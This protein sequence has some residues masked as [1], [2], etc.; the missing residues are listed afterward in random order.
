MIHRVETHMYTT[1]PEQIIYVFSTLVSCILILFQGTLNC[2]A[3]QT[4]LNPN[5]LDES[6]QEIAIRTHPKGVTTGIT[7]TATNSTL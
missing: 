3:D 7:I 1:Q 2:L 5:Q 4:F 6:L